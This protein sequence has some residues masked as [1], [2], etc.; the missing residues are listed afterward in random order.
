MG[1][2]DGAIFSAD[3]HSPPSIVHDEELGVFEERTDEERRRV[4]ASC[5]AVLFASTVSFSFFSSLEKETPIVYPPHAI[6]N[7]LRRVIPMLGYDM[8]MVQCN[9]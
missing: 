6:A 7:K 2:S 9:S 8:R 4:V 5:R 3:S 1:E